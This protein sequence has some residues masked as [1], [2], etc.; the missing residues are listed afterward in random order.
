MNKKYQ[1]LLRKR[2]EAKKKLVKATKNF[3]GFKHE[4]SASEL[5][6]LNVKL[7]QAHL[8]SIEEEIRELEKKNEK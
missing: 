8:V 6:D 3:K 5:Q 7:S 2:E 1:E 4:D